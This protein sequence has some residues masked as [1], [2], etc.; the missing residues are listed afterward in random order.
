MPGA[1]GCFAAAAAIGKVV[2]MT[3]RLI[4]DRKGRDVVTVRPD[5]TISEVAKILSER[6]IGAVV[7]S[8]GDGRIEGI[9]SERDIVRV[10]GSEGASVLDRPASSIMTSDVRVCREENTINEM[11]EIMTAGRFRHLPVEKMGRLDGIV[12]IGDVV[13]Q[14]IEEIE[15]EAEQIRTYIATA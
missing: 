5:Q 2:P 12:S 6:R 4:L 8:G 11:M 13:K 10:V 3:V 15:R 14:R 9:V 7:V 1:E